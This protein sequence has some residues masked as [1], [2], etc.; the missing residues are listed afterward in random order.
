MNIALA[1]PLPLPPI[2]SHQSTLGNPD[3]Q[4]QPRHEL[5]RAIL[6]GGEAEQAAWTRRWGEHALDALAYGSS[7]DAWN[8]LQNVQAALDHTRRQLAAANAA[9]KTAGI[10][11]DPK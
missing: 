11:L 9:L 10:K 8:R 4:V 2:S 5:D 3:N 1:A 6:F 7:S